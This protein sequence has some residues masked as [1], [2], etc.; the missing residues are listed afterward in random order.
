MWTRQSEAGREHWPAFTEV[1]K[2]SIT[3][4]FFCSGFERAKCMFS[5]SD[6]FKKAILKTVFFKKTNKQTKIQKAETQTKSRAVVAH[7]FNPS[8]WEERQTDLCEFEDAWSIE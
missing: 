5:A 7:T 1:A 8:T 3:G 2:V 6:I 4:L